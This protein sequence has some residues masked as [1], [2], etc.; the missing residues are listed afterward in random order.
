MG[1]RDGRGAIGWMARHR[2]A[3]NLLML[4]LAFGGL[5]MTTR[6]K[7]EVFPSFEPNTVSV[8]VAYPG[9]T[10]EQIEQGVVLPVEAAVQGIA[11][12]RKMTATA[13]EGSGSVVLELLEGVDKQQVYQEIQQAVDAIDIFPRDAEAPRV[14]MRAWQRDVMDLVVF[15]DASEHALRA[16][17]EQIRDGLLQAPGVTAVELDGVR[18]L[19]IHIDIDEG[20][21]RAHG[22]SFREVADIVARNALDRSA[23]RV[24]T[25]SGDLL[26]EVNERRDWASEFAD[27]VVVSGA[28]GALV[29]L[30]DIATLSE[31]FAD[32]DRA[33]YFNG[34][35]AVGLEVYRVAE[36]TPI[37]VADAVYAALPGLVADLP[38]GIEVEVR[39]DNSQVYRDRLQL[40][41]KNAFL[42]LL[43]VL[44]LLSIF[45]E[46][47]LAF[48]VTVGIPTS[49]LGAMLFL[50]WMG[51]SINM[52]SLF[53]FIIAL[54]IVVDDAIVA[55]ENIYEYRQ[56]GMGALAAAIR[57]AKDI[58]VPVT[59][60]ILTNIVAFL[61]LSFIPGWFGQLWGVV[62]LVVGT[63]FAISLIEALVILPAHLG[64]MKEGS[65]TRVGAKLHGA[66]Q[67]FSRAYSRFIERRYGPLLRL[68]LQHRYLTLS[69]SVVLLLVVLAIPLSGRMGFELMPRVES[70]A[71]SASA[72]LPY[73]SSREQV[74]RVRE[75]LVA[76]AERVIAEHGGER[77]SR[78]VYAR[79]DET[80]VDVRAY[81]APPGQRPLSTAEFS[82]HWR[83]ATG[84]LAGVESLSFAFDRGGP[85]GG[86]SVSLLLSHRDTD[87]LRQASRALAEQLEGYAGVSDVDDG[88]AEGRPQ[89]TFRLTESARA[90]GLS[91]DDIASQVRNA[92]YGAEAFKQLRG[93]NEVT[94]RVR[95]D[96][97][98]R[99]SEA[100]VAGLMLR[101]PAGTYVPLAQVARIEPG[102]SLPQINREDGRR[103]LTVSANVTPAK[104]TSRVLA[105]LEREVLPQ[106]MRDY[107]GL[108]YARA[109]RQ[110]TAQDAMG[111][112]K[113]TV[114]LALLAIYALLAIPFRSYVQPA[115]IMVAIPFG[116]VG[117]ILGHL[118]MGYSLGLISVMGIIAL[119]GVV[120]NDSLVMIDYA[121]AR[122]REGLS[123]FDAIAQAG[124]RRFRPIMLTTLTTFGGLAP[125]IFETSR[126]ARFMIPMAISLGYGILFATAILLL[127]IPSLY[128]VVEDARRLL[129]Q[130]EGEA[131]GGEGNLATR[132]RPIPGPRTDP[133]RRG[134]PQA[135]GRR[136]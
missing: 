14:S 93:R 79:S 124:V 59:F 102:R 13:S 74:A 29:R 123:A 126:Q 99:P 60:S 16:A 134:S 55:G 66:Q 11:G 47:K 23:G 48:W 9:A 30:G 1:G 61:P 63:V 75:A 92:F 88:Y 108:S 104:D 46:F 18:P 32:S 107:P 19:E 112:F 89:W 17:A 15:G 118:V 117:A 76:A 131:A 73:G 84:E 69:L 105:A 40:L 106:L 51:V 50:P 103:T 45:L 71:A 122:R 37:S 95:L 78:G 97:P 6:I 3:P 43:L 31:G 39:D 58:A 115:I 54:G 38:P 62:P 42:G 2:V 87:T 80:S 12:I 26:L 120:V 132:G 56:R 91:A 64:H 70:D 7:Q 20:R 121:N 111:S 8:S 133:R 34:R 35:R 110:A 128:M 53:A 125:M 24:R 36:Q 109:G 98:A 135:A 41:L 85:G 101:T 25:G 81:L 83:A 113:Y 27:V 114:G 5:F 96:R 90:L 136:G 49:F 57:G 119:G 72:T 100:E 33:A 67:R 22:L 116:V 52:I 82:R 4:V 130:E 127:L 94:V 28:R 10:P 44:A 77:L 68:S 129:G 21:L 65:R 86:A